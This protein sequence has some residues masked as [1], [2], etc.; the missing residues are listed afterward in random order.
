MT[1]VDPLEKEYRKGKTK[2][3]KVFRKHVYVDKNSTT[4]LIHYIRNES[5]AVVAPHG[6]SKKR[7]CVHTNL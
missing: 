5:I 4:V 7:Q 2:S 3:S 6:N 1:N